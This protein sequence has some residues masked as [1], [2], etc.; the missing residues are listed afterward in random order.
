MIRLL[1]TGAAV[2]F[3]GVIVGVYIALVPIT[4]LADKETAALLSGPAGRTD[5]GD[6]PVI[7]HGGSFHLEI[8][9]DV[10]PAAGS[11][12]ITAKDLTRAYFINYVSPSGAALPVRLSVPW[13][14][15]VCDSLDAGKCS[16]NGVK[17]ISSSST[18]ITISPLN[19][20]SLGVPATTSGYHDYTLAT[21]NPDPHP[22][23]VVITSGA[24][25]SAIYQCVP[26]KPQGQMEWATCQVE[27]AI[28]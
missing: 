24:L 26:P 6:P 28:K 16:S 27:L 8:P 13:E 3:I 4:H 1:V 21:G 5:P 25:S 18:E 19:Q 17:A 15:D 23:F 22:N 20:T 12:K 14:V 7:M 11:V 9:G 10:T 2:A